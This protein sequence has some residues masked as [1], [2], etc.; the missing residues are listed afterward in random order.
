[1]LH[2]SILA[3]LARNKDFWIADDPIFVFHDPA[4]GT[5]LAGRAQHATWVRVLASHQRLLILGTRQ[6]PGVGRVGSAQVSV[7]AGSMSKIDINGK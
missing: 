4:Q 1:M 6:S 3:K 2:L 7:G 5:R